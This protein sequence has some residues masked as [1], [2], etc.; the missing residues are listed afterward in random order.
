MSTPR[1]SMTTTFSS[2]FSC[3]RTART[4]STCSSSSATR[5]LVPECDSRYSTSAAGEVG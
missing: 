2:A 1:G 3:L 5:T 4:L